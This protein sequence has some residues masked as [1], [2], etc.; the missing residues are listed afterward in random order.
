[1][2][3]SKYL[4]MHDIAHH[5]HEIA[6]HCPC[7]AGAAAASTPSQSAQRIVSKSR[8]TDLIAPSLVNLPNALSADYWLNKVRV[9]EQL[10][11][12]QVRTALKPGCCGKCFA[13]LYPYVEVLSLQ[14]C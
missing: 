3:D 13:H 7:F 14:M 1:M 5:M 2:S 8:A 6:H 9:Q 12:H 10:G 11:N 4:N